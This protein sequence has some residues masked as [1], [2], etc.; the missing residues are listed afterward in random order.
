MDAPSLPSIEGPARTRDL[1][2]VYLQKFEALQ[3][4]ERGIP[5]SQFYPY[6]KLRDL[7]L[8]FRLLKKITETKDHAQILCENTPENMSENRYPDVLPY[9]DTMVQLT[10]GS[11]VNADFVDGAVG[12][13]ENLF[14]VT[15]GPMT[16]TRRKFWD[17]VWECD[18]SL[19][20]MTCQMFESGQEKCDQYYPADSFNCSITV[21]PYTIQLTKLKEKKSGLFLRRF[22]LSHEDSE[23][24]LTV[25]HL[26]VTK[27]PDQG[28]PD[29]E[30][31]TES[32]NYLIYY[33]KKR[34]LPGQ[35]ILVH[36]SAGCGRSGAL[37]GLY[38]M[39]TALETLIKEESSPRVSVFGTVRRLRE[40]RWGLVQTKEQYAFLYSYME[41]WISSYLAHSAPEEDEFSDL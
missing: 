30:T 17:M 10:S 21:G 28:S 13:A 24:V 11:Y 27:W 25:D 40:Q 26:H 38:C 15:Q 19:I 16:G 31:D 41:A 18:V 14:I 23:R 39:V 33:M 35:K 8:E 36:C 1:S 6:M 22:A 20:V 9:R 29:L 37:V 4:A 3:E 12:E 5:M 7:E 2:Y 32:L 34:T